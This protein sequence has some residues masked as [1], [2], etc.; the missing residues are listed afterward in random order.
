MIADR[1]IYKTPDGKIVGVAPQAGI[2]VIPA[3]TLLNEPMLQE[4]GLTWDEKAKRLVAPD[5]A[6]AEAK[7]KAG[8]K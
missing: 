6:E 7:A 8:G 2:V 3:N 4:F 1:D 5:E